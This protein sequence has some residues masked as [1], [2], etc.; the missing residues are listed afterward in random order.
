MLFKGLGV[1][2][3]TQTL[4]WLRTCCHLC[5]LINGLALHRFFSSVNGKFPFYSTVFQE[6]NKESIVQQFEMNS[7]ERVLAVIKRS[8][9]F[10]WHK[11]N[12]ERRQQASQV[13]TISLLSGSTDQSAARKPFVAS[14]SASSLRDAYSV[15]LN[16]HTVLDGCLVITDKAVYETRP[17]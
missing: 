10:Y 3:D 7:G 12:E 17:R 6:F 11:R 9:P 5:M 4:C 1:Q 2:K 13:E 16:T 8:Y 15:Q 14:Q